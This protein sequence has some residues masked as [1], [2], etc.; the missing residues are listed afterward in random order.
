MNGQSCLRWA[1]TFALGVGVAVLAACSVTDKILEV[2]NPGE[3]PIRDLN[4]PQLVKVLVAGVIGDFVHM[5]DDPFIWRGGMFTDEQV[6]GI[7]WEQTARLNQ[8]IVQ[9]DEGDADLMF[10]SI[11]RALRQAEDVS[12]R[13]RMFQ[14]NPKTDA[15]VAKTLDSLVAKTLAFA[16]YSYVAMG[17]AMCEATVSRL[18]PV[19][20][21]F[22]FGDRILPPDSLF[23]RAVARF[24]EAVQMATAA[25]NNQILNLARVG[26]ARAHLTL[27]DTAEVITWVSQVPPDFKWWLEYAEIIPRERN[28]LY[29]RVTGANHALGVHPHFLN[30]TFGDT[31]IRST[32]TDP[33][34]QHT[35]S[36]STGHNALT[37]LYKPYQGLRF[38]GYNGQ[39]IASGGRP[40][41]YEPQ[42]N[43]LL[44]DYLEAQHHLA[45]AQ[46]PTS[47]TLTFVN[48]RRAVGNQPPVTLSGDALM[49]ELREQRGR[50][51]YMGGFRLGD[52]R[53][54][55]KR[56]V[57]DFFPTGVHVNAQWGLY[58]TATCFPLP[59][60]EYE[61]NPNLE[62]P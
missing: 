50:D 16:G 25:G 33:R 55:L 27:G 54:W 17:E 13:L 38:E 4:N 2:Q 58:G 24:Q 20:G 7:N 35:P 19:T 32:Q 31:G 18:D 40:I 43:I 39:T 5:Y 10:T 48:A 21:D 46:G 36:W 28:V 34:I 41:L 12:T 47:A 3:I 1:R 52:L 57:G 62:V 60:E 45:E 51:L 37:K 56:G 53:R 42:T 22:I 61:G 9:F 6:T 8:R 26:M 59:L 23:L 14:A 49:A 11:S 15:L 44:A 30:G 29:T